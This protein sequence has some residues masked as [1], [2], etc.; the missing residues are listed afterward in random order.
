MVCPRGKMKNPVAKWLARRLSTGK[1]TRLKQNVN[2]RTL[3][4]NH[5]WHQG[6]NFKIFIEDL[7]AE[8]HMKQD[9]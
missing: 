5:I 7:Y 6:Q 9:D 2:L 3:R 4:Q 1:N 8:L